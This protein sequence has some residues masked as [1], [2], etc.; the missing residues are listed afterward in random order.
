MINEILFPKKTERIHKIFYNKQYRFFHDWA[1]LA[2]IQVVLLDDG[3]DKRVY[4]GSRSEAFFGPTAEHYSILVDG[5]QLII[6]FSDLMK[7]GM[8]TFDPRLPYVKHKYYD[9][10]ECRQIKNLYPIGSEMDIQESSYQEFFDLC[11]QQLYTA[12]GGIVCSNQDATNVR[13]GGRRAKVQGLLKKWYG[14]NADTGFVWGNQREFWHKVLNCFVSVVIPGACNSCIDRGHTEQFALGICVVSPPLKTPFPFDILPQ[15]GVHYVQC[16]D[17]FSDLRQVIHW[18]YTNK[19]EC[20]RIGRNAADLYRA[21]YAPKQY[22]AWIEI[23][24]RKHQEKE[25]SL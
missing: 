14:N 7:E 9:V 12:Q 10:P 17:D 11:E 23:V 24:L 13:N 25:T 2:G 5:K 3:I 15:S 20:V 19:D 21:C 4:G 18:C 1:K 6:E 16:K 22:F 8:K